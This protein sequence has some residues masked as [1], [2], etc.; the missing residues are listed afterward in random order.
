MLKINTILYLH[1]RCRIIIIVNLRTYCLLQNY[2]VGRRDTF[3]IS[4]AQWE[5]Y[6][7]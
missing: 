2:G 3:T 1:R 7:F 4:A 6:E 5:K